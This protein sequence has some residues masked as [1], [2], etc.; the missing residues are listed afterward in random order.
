MHHWV[1]RATFDAFALAGFDYHLNVI[2]R[3]EDEV[4]LAYKRMLDITV[5]K[6][7][8]ILSFLEIHFPRLIGL[9]PNDINREVRRSKAII[10]VAGEKMLKLKRD[11][12][13]GGK[14]NADSEDARHQRDLLSLMSEPKLPSLVE[15]IS[16]S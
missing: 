2:Q 12:I 5:N 6:G 10:K 4:Y 1:G 11:A 7:Q 3:E 8:S 15:T 14:A 9:I 16:L 13:L